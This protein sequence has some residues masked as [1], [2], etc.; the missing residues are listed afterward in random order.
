MLE[1]IVDICFY[2]KD[3]QHYYSSGMV[4]KGMNTGIPKASLIYKVDL[5]KGQNILESLLKTMSVAFVKYNSF[6]VL[7]YPFKYLREYIEMDEANNTKT[8]NKK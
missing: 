1:G 3:N 8:F 7:P 2:E 6:T 4:G 5:L